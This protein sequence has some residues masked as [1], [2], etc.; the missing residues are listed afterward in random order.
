MNTIIGLRRYKAGAIQN[1]NTTLVL[2]MESRVSLLK[3]A[4][5]AG[6]H[7]EL[8]ANTSPSAQK[9]ARKKVQNLLLFLSYWQNAEYLFMTT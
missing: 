5:F 9:C 4:D 1:T 2:R 3:E 6:R 8:R 7:E